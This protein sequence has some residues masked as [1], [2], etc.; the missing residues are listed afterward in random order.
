MVVVMTR[1]VIADTGEK[2]RLTDGKRRR[3]RRVLLF[4]KWLCHTVKYENALR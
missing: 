1:T 4:P 3:R 2:K